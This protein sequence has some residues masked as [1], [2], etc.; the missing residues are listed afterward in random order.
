MSWW[1]LPPDSSRGSLGIFVLHRTWRE[2]VC[3]EANGTQPEGMTQV[4]GIY[5]T[6]KNERSGAMRLNEEGGLDQRK[7]CGCRVAR[8]FAI[9]F[10]DGVRA[11]STR[12]EIR[13]PHR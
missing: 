13:C 2:S 7:T 12:Y 4:S 1:R 11:Q 6:N 3:E 10:F 9:H 8:N 5:K